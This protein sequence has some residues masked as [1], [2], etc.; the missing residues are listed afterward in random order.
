MV[1]NCNWLRNL[2]KPSVLHLY[3]VSFDGLAAF[4]DLILQLFPLHFLSKD[5]FVSSITDTSSLWELKYLPHL[6]W[7]R[8]LHHRI[9]SA[10]AG[11]YWLGSTFG[12][13][14]DVVA[15]ITDY[16]P[17]SMQYLLEFAPKKTPI[18][19]NH[20]SVAEGFV[21]VRYVLIQHL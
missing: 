4:Q 17:F 13:V 8:I 3:Y 21:S 14:D 1:Q 16:F 11:T 12:L 19:W 9:G 6:F 5:G 10:T 7:K 20:S 18:K 2:Q 15:E